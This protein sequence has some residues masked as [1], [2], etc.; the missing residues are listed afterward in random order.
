[1]KIAEISQDQ[2]L[3]SAKDF[4]KGVR[5]IKPLKIEASGRRYYR[6]LSRTNSYVMCHDDSPINGQSVFVDRSNKL[7]N[8]NVRVPKILKYDSEKFLTI[9]EDIGDNSLILKEN[10]Y[11]DSSLVFNALSLLN[12]MHKA[13]LNGIDSTFSIGLESHTKKFSKIL[14][15]EFLEI[16]IFDEFKDFLGAMRPELMN[17]QWGNCHFDFERRN[18]HEMANGELVLLD[19]QDLCFGPIGIDLAGILLDHYVDCDLEVLR[20]YC[21]TFSEI[22][23]Y[24]LSA[25]DVYHATCWGGLQ[26]NLRIMGTLTNLFLRF[27]RPFRMKD[28]PQILANTITLSLALNQKPLA[29]FLQDQVAPELHKKLGS[30]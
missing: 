8:S 14:C 30:L 26:R 7:A 18:I 28:L 21:S 11:K 22:S 16:E 4:D 12:D 29:G 5:D 23:C 27:N 1:M 2:L 9:Q 10:F 3:E 24:D 19:F 6:A 13:E 25:D 15:K 20:N 17:Q